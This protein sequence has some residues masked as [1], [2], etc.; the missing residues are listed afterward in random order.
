VASKQEKRQSE[1]RAPKDSHP[2]SLP[3]N[4]R[5]LVPLD[6]S[7]QSL[8]ALPVA[9]GLAELL[10][11]SLHLVYVAE[12]LVPAREA[13]SAVGLQPEQARGAVL[14]P[15]AGP[16]ATSIVR[17][18]Q[19]WESVVIVLCTH[20]GTAEGAKELGAVAEEVLRQ[21]SCPVV[22]VRPQLTL[23]TWAVRRILL[24][25]DG[26]PTAAGAIGPAADL[27]G[28]A[29]AELVVLHVAALGVNRPVERGTMTGPRYVDQ[30]QHEWPAWGREFLARVR[31]LG[32]LPTEL[33]LR[34]ILATGE[35][36]DAIVRTA[37][38]HHSDLIVLAWQGRWESG[39]AATLKQVIAT[40]PCPV[41]IVRVGQRDDARPMKG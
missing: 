19:E 39:R 22:L 12:R 20:T 14:Q 9:R 25:H 8:A 17:L 38:E 23:E 6:G 10:E 28:R 16:P 2:K 30:R 34:L 24:P 3:T 31:A 11:G 5:I 1:S 33:E 29:R 7:A 35:P 37:T 40:A 32:K 21:A 4:P 27:A 26:T 41:L 18:A 15:V 36:G 13:L